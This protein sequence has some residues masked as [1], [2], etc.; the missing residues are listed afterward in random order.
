MTSVQ[1]LSLFLV[2]IAMGWFY[3]YA[4]YTKIIDQSWSAAG[5]INNAKSFKPFFSLLA[6]PSILPIIDF[7]NKWG[8]TLLGISLIIGLFVRFSSSLGVIVMLLYYLALDF[9][10]PNPNAYIADQHII[11]S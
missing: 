4:G 6:D 9:P 3:F 7:L 5:Y 2:R 11:Y 10:H 8:L 1:K